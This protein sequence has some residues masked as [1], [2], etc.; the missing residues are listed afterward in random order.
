M[1]DPSSA[2]RAKLGAGSPSLIMGVS[3]GAG[4]PRS[5]SRNQAWNGVGVLNVSGTDAIP[6]LRLLDKWDDDGIERETVTAQVA[7][8][9]DWNSVASSIAHATLYPVP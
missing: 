1:M 5:R 8:P 7:I 4:Y 2:W 3:G 6:Q 9:G